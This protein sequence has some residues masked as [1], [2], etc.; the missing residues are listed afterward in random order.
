[1]Y[2]FL[3]KNPSMMGKLWFIC[4][5]MYLIFYV[6]KF[7]K[8]KVFLCFPIQMSIHGNGRAEDISSSEANMGV[9]LQTGIYGCL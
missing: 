2:L 4:S 7:F 9:N 5:I 6:V 1:M 3:Q 8:W